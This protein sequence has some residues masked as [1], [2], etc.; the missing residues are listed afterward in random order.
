MK[1]S[2]LRTKTFLSLRSGRTA[3]EQQQALLSAGKEYS[4]GSLLMHAR[5]PSIAAASINEVHQRFA[6][7]MS[8]EVFKK[9]GCGRFGLCHAGDVR[10]EEYAR[11]H[12]EGVFRRQWLGIRDVENR[13][14]QVTGLQRLKE[15]RINE[16]RAAPDIDQRSAC[17]KRLEELA[18]ENAE[19]RWSERQKAY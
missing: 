11:V 9:Y 12:P 3:A 5:L 19:R 13:A 2:G 16:V 14:G 7:L 18:I 4:F 6:A 10:R 8:T 1:L 15:I 17:G